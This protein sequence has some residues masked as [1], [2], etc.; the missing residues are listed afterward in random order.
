M[1]DGKVTAMKGD[2]DNN[3]NIRNKRGGLYAQH[4]A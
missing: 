4:S 3:K 2:K 1:H